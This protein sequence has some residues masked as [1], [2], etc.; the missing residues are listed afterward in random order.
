MWICGEP[1]DLL[2]DMSWVHLAMI[3]EDG[4]VSSHL[5]RV[6]YSG[7]HEHRTMSQAHLKVERRTLSTSI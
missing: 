2:D 4:V 5:D 6:N 7:G 1:E 3:L